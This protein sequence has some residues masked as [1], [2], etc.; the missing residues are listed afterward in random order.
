M[1]KFR[2]LKGIIHSFKVASA[3]AGKIGIEE[4]LPFC[5]VFSPIEILGSANQML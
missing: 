2:L 4:I 1:L 3:S 5:I